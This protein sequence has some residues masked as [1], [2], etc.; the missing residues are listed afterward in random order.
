MTLTRQ[1]PWQMFYSAWD[2]LSYTFSS[3]S[4]YPDHS[5]VIGADIFNEPWYSYV[6]ATLRPGR[7]S[8]RLRAT[9]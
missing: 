3:R 9:G 1:S 2:Y 4:G 5:A 8:C 6:G 7:L